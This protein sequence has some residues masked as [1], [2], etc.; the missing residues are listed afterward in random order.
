[1]NQHS[2]RS[3]A[4][5]TIIV[6]QRSI[7]ECAISSDVITAKFH[8]VDLAGSERAKR[9]G[10]VGMRFKESVTINCGLLALGNVIS[11]LGDERK[12]CQHVPYRES[13]LTRMLQDSL[14][15]NSRTCMIACISTAGTN[16]EETLNTLKY[17]NRA[18]NIRNKPVINRDP[19]SVMLNQLRHEILAL[20]M[21]L[22][23]SRTRNMEL[24]PIRGA[25]SPESLLEDQSHQEF[26]DD[27]RFVFLPSFHRR[28][29]CQVDS[30][31]SPSIVQLLIIP[32]IF[33]E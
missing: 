33:L 2:S 25:L 17:A 28:C 23:K 31:D 3:H 8:L 14:G 32:T 24:E 6:E 20:Q 5:F 7:V 1:M 13:K 27:I 10:A 9:T 26:L 30:A 29:Y 18:R 4:I 19:Q 15:G 11:A 16:F 21:E 22:L 12:R